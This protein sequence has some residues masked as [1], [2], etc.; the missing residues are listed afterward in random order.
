LDRSLDAAA[1]KCAGAARDDDGFRRTQAAEGAEV[2]VVVVDVGDEHRVEVLETAE[3]ERLG[4]AEH[5]DALAEQRVGE[6]ADAVQLDE[7]RRVSDPA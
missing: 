5:D 6:E 1:K 7:N 4:A 2:E 3:V